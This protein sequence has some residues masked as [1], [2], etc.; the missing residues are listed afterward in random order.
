MSWIPRPVPV[1]FLCISCIIILNTLYH[2]ANRNLLSTLPTTWTISTESTAAYSA[3]SNYGSP[4]CGINYE[5][6]GEGLQ[7][8]TITSGGRERYYFVHL[9]RN[10][11][12]TKET[13]LLILYHAATGSANGFVR[14]VAVEDA[15]VNPNMIVVAPQA[16][17]RRWQGAP[18]SPE[19]VDDLQFAADLVGQ[20]KKDYCI[21][22]DKVYTLGH[23]NGAGFISY[24][25]C[26]EYGDAYKAFA[27]ISPTLYTEVKGQEKPCKIRDTRPMLSLHCSGDEIAP[28]LGGMRLEALLPSIPGWVKLWAT[29]NKCDEEPISYSGE[30]GTD[31]SYTCRGQVNAVRHYMVK[32]HGHA[33][34]GREK[35]V[36]MD[37]F[38]TPAILDWFESLSESREAKSLLDY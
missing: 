30:N 12:P 24:L 10:Y 31:T 28:Y 7:N 35:G 22:E 1:V 4:G 18:Y 14:I 2:T 29:R 9:P 27:S 25:A 11:D 5:W 6:A 21:N 26:T 36:N 13:E 37:P 23:S 38:V 20:V 34:Q 33:Y 8:F 32:D 16:I 15:T 3:I 19:G 17:N